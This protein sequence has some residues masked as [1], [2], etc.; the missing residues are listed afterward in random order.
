MVAESARS[1]DEGDDDF[2]TGF[3]FDVGGSTS[4]YEAQPAWE[5]EGGRGLLSSTPPPL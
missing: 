5:F 2:N 3:K 1:R 4:A